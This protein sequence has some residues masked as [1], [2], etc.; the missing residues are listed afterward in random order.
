MQNQHGA[1]KVGRS[2][3]PAFRLK[4]LEKS[5]GCRIR[6][7]AALREQGGDEERVHL[8][9]RNYQFW[10]EWFSGCASCKKAV[11]QTLRLTKVRFPF[12]WKRQRAEQWR[13]T[14]H[15]ASVLPRM[16]KERIRLIGLMKAV[17]IGLHTNAVQHGGRWLDRSIWF[18]MNQRINRLFFGDDHPIDVTQ[19]DVPPYT[20]DLS[21]AFLLWPEGKRPTEWTRHYSGSTVELNCCVAGLGE[22]WK[23][24][25]ERIKARLN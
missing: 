4:V 17:E 19:I 8:R 12:S 23:I 15:L 14:M 18:E 6:L 3:N 21:A 5:T 11:S 24:D 13:R 25:S 10:G 1:I 9:L 7:I 22:L 2:S 16:R 20:T